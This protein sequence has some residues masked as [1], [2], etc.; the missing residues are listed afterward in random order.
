MDKSCLIHSFTH[1][2]SESCCLLNHKRQKRYIWPDDLLLTMNSRET[3]QNEVE[4]ISRAC[5]S[6]S[7]VIMVNG[8]KY[9]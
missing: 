3:S 9:L 7:D 8:I 5:L 1:A 6:F 2:S 4:E